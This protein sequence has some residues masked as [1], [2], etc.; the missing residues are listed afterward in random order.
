MFVSLIRADPFLAPAAVPPEPWKF[1][2]LSPEPEIASTSQKTKSPE[3][4]RVF[5]QAE[6]Q[7]F[8]VTFDPSSV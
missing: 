6:L 4:A 2:C 5:L 7:G 8:C 1:K 3:T